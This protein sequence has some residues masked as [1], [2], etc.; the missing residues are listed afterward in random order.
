MLHYFFFNHQHLIF[1]NIETIFDC[2]STEMDA[3]LFFQ[4]RGLLPNKQL[5]DHDMKLYVSNDEVYGD[6]V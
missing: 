5:C 4:K 2:S 3:I 6:A 1:I